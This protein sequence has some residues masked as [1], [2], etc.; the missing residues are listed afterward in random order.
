MADVNELD[1]AQLSKRLSEILGLPEAGSL[2]NNQIGVVVSGNIDDLI[3]RLA[4]ITKDLQLD[5]KPITFSKEG[6]NLLL[7]THGDI[8]NKPS[9]IGK[10]LDFLATKIDLIQPATREFRGKISI[11]IDVKSTENTQQSDTPKASFDSPDAGKLSIDKA[12]EKFKESF[13]AEYKIGSQSASDYAKGEKYDDASKEVFAA[14]I[15]ATTKAFDA[16]VEAKAAEQGK[17]VDEVRNDT[18]TMSELRKDFAVEYSKIVDDGNLNKLDLKDEFAAETKRFEALKKD[19]ETQRDKSLEAQKQKNT[20]K[21]SFE[22]PE[23]EKNTPAADLAGSNPP[24]PESAGVGN[25]GTLIQDNAA[26]IGRVAASVA[27]IAVPHGSVL[28]GI[29]QTAITAA[30]MMSADKAQA[31]ATNDKA[32][33][34]F[35]ETVG[36]DS[37][38]N[39]KSGTTDSKN[40]GQTLTP[41]EQKF[42]DAYVAAKKDPADQN[43]QEQFRDAVF[44][45]ADQV[46]GKDDR[47]FNNKEDDNAKKFRAAVDKALG[48]VD[49]KSVGKYADAKELWQKGHAEGLEQMVAANK[50]DNS[51][52]AADLAKTG[53]GDLNNDGGMSAGEAQRVRSFKGIKLDGADLAAVV[54]I[55]KNATGGQDVDNTQLATDVG[56]A[57]SIGAGQGANRVQSPPRT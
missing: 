34:T 4:E 40:P 2:R 1:T 13:G 41:A 37:T 56:G 8:T 48:D 38:S 6:S 14:R 5:G 30:S 29:A 53:V 7:N 44:A 10:T 54:N 22:L 16:M 35:A 28:N 3:S 36:S 26:N 12:A 23:P 42:R 15:E 17:S 47:R 49:G 46:D 31:T 57:G 43:L 11:E 18:K 21:A 24:S 33:D 55:S 39:N 20:P 45:L 51:N 19:F 9:D 25:I 32:A 52:K 27:S 50:T